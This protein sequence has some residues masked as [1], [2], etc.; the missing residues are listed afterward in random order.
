V[1]IARAR[2]DRDGAAM[3]A[4]AVALA[5]RV[6]ALETAEAV[7]AQRQRITGLRRGDAALLGKLVIAL[8]SLLGSDEEFIARD[9]AETTHPIVRELLGNRSKKSIGRLLSRACDV[10]IGDYMII[11]RGVELRVRKYC[12]VG[13]LKG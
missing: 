8:R 2:A 4:W 3:P 9:L 5:A 12:V 13:V 6:A 1:T 7:R 10:P 11:A